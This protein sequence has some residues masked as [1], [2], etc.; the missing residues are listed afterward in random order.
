MA[1]LVLVLNTVRSACLQLLLVNECVARNSPSL[2]IAPSVLVGKSGLP[3]LFYNSAVSSPQPL[4]RRCVRVVFCFLFRSDVFQDGIKA[5]RCVDYPC[6]KAVDDIIL[7]GKDSTI[8]RFG[9]KWLCVVHAA[10][11]GSTIH[12]S[13]AGLNDVGEPILLYGQTSSSLTSSL[14]RCCCSHVA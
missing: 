2:G 12:S 9:R 8:A 3:I 13:G 1:L 10:K 7:C 14:V 11:T 6:S 5:A 4:A